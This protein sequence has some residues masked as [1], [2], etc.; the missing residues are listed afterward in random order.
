MYKSS[1]LKYIIENELFI[2]SPFLSTRKFISYCKDCAILTSREQLELFEKLKIFYPIARVKYPKVRKKVEYVNNGRRYRYLG[3]LKDGEKWSGDLRE[4]YS[5]FLF[6]KEYAMDWFKKELLWQPS[7][8]PFQS[9]ETFKDKNGE[10]QIESFYSIFQCY[11]LY[12]LSKATTMEIKAE[13]C[14]TYSKK[15]INKLKNRIFDLAKIAINGIQKN[16]IRGEIAVSTCQIISNRY[17]PITQTDYRTIHLSIPIYYRNWDWYKYCSNWDAKA[18]LNDIGMSIDEIKKLHELV[19]LD[20]KSI[21]PLEKWYELTQFVSLDQKKK[22][23]G[24][25]LL[26]QTLYSMEYMLRLFYEELTNNKLEQ[27]HIWPSWKKDRSYRDDVIQNDIK[28]LEF[29]TNRYHLNPRPKLILVVEGYGEYEN[30]PRIAKALG[31][32]FN[33]SAIRIENLKGIGEFKKLERYIDN[34]HNLQTVV[35]ILLDNENRSRQLKKKIIGIPSKYG[36]NRKITKS[37][38]IKI[39]NKNFEFDNFT[40][41]EIAVSMSKQSQGKYNFKKKEINFARKG[42]K[43]IQDIYK[44]RVGFDLNK[45]ELDKD[46]TNIII[47]E[48]EENNIKIL[49]KKR[50]IIDEIIKITKIASR[51]YFPISKDSWRRNQESGFFGDVD[52]NKKNL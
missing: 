32:D 51:N 4:E 25:S 8:Q 7:S 30:I 5:N 29:L 10:G 14:I 18:V 23:K 36:V 2:T 16:G 12:N 27:P 33:I 28:Y 34:Y 26:A 11:S 22:L 42:N 21:D 6:E 13:K 44:D 19:T 38:Y 31:L 24:R 40:D 3:I 46:L 20:A 1:I 47:K 41:D 37:E 17:F 49:K 15:D 35:Y 45:R 9:W 39:W 48:I 50:N 52:V 43:K